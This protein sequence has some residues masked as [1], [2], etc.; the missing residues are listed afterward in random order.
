[1]RENIVTRQHYCLVHIASDLKA[2]YLNDPTKAYNRVSKIILFK[3]YYS[4]Y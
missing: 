2:K 4:L 1:M 3:K